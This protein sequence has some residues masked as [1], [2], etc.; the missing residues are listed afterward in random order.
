[1]LPAVRRPLVVAFAVLAFGYSV[2]L[3]LGSWPQ[4]HPTFEVSALVLATLLVSAR[5]VQ[6]SSAKEWVIMPPSFVV[7]FTA[8]V[9]LGP[10]A[11]VLVAA[12][13]AAMQ[14]LTE[15]RQPHQFRKAVFHTAAV[16]LAAQAAGMVH[17]LLGGTI[18]AFTWPRQAVPLAGALITY[19]F[20]RAVSAEIVMPLFSRHPVNRSWPMR[21]LRSVNNYLLGAAAAT[22]FAASLASGDWQILLLITVPLLLAFR[23]YCA[24]VTR[25]EDDHQLAEVIESLDRERARAEDY[26]KRTEARLALAADG[27]ND[28]LWEWDLQRQRLYCSSRWRSLLGLPAADNVGPVTEWFARVHQDDRRELK[29]AFEDHFSGK[30]DHFLHVHRIRHQDGTYRLYLSRGVAVR[31]AGRQAIRIA[32]SL[33]DMTERA[34]AQ[35]RRESVG[36][37]DPLTGLANRAVFVERLGRRLDEFKQRLSM[38]AFAVLY[39]DLDRFKVVNDSLGHLVGDELLTAVSRR[40]ESCLRPGDDIARL[41]GDEFAI[42]LNELG[43]ANQANAI[44]FRIQEALSAPFSIG[45]REVFTSASIGIACGPAQYDN[46]DEI[47]RDADTAMYQAK[48]HGKARHELFDADMHARELDRLEL[49]NDL[50]HAVTTNGFEI[51]YQPIVLIDSGMCIGFES[52]ARWTR[53]GEAVPP[54]TFIPL[55]EELGIIEPLGTWMLQEACSTFADWKRRF[56]HAGLDYVTVNVSSRQ[57]MQQNFLRIV[58]QAVARAGLEPCDLRIEVTETAVID[59]PREA[60]KVLH[61]LREFGTKIYLDDFGCG[62]SSLSHLARLPVDALKIDRSFVKTLLL[63][64]RPAIVESIMALARTLNTGVIAEGIE[65]E[66]QGRELERLGCTH[67]QGFL[68]SRPVSAKAAEAIIAANQPLGRQLFDDAE[69]LSDDDSRP[70]PPAD[71]SFEWP[72]ELVSQRRA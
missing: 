34:I 65:H 61:D 51:H 72:D 39:L 46:S 24:Y 17:Q 28:G 62:Y 33:T 10:H 70:A 4:P 32:G 26:L 31:G 49:E 50:R 25:L 27:A 54:V 38:T 71:Q 6:H 14:G 53:N 7:D 9:L 64:E 60:A 43:D 21:F 12:V 59:R 18:G 37:L 63:P 42:L 19:C 11:M 67:A 40:L 44:A 55:A 41:G 69:A 5:A 16:V 56:P 47:M 1:M 8:L 58:E 48:S 20:V 36:F 45:G 23:T 3:D 52:L 57:L 29:A 68:F 13:G 2:W 66:A 22:G 30:T 15:P 35:G